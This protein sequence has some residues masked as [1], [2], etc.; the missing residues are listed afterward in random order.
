MIENE[1][2]IKVKMSNVT[3]HFYFIQIKLNNI[4]FVIFII[5]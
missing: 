5:F 1:Q 2:K 4:F 3:L